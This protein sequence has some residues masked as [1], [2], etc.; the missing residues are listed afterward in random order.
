MGQLEDRAEQHGHRPALLLDAAPH[1]CLP[2]GESGVVDQQVDRPG[3]H[4]RAGGGVS[5]AG[6][7]GSRRRGH[8]QPLHHP[9][10]I[11]RL[12][13]VRGQDLDVHAADLP[14][15][16][17]DLLQIGDRAGHQDQIVVGLGQLPGDLQPDAAGSARDECGSHA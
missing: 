8:A 16:L 10:Q 12:G 6:R 13:Q 4:R 14:D 17:G 3:L 7:A 15:P 9:G 2:D 11:L 1:E 5:A